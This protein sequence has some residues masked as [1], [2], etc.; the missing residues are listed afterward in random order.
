M[1]KHTD[2][3]FN[4]AWRTPV[5]IRIGDGIRERIDG[6][7]A[8]LAA[9]LHRWPSTDHREFA[10]AKRRCVDA[11]GRHGSTELARDAFTQAALAVKVLA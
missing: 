6:P 7:Q 10:I 1:Q 8:A 9:L 11:V 4:V 5:Y 2:F 3:D